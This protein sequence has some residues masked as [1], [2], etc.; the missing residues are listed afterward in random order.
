MEKWG[1]N[2][3]AEKKEDEGGEERTNRLK[4]RIN[5]NVFARRDTEE[6]EIEV[7]DWEADNYEW[8]D[9]RTNRT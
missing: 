5:W 9:E 3:V 1:C 4:M 7:T 8:R 6:N 2:W